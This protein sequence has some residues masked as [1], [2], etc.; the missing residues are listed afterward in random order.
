VSKPEFVDVDVA[1]SGQSWRTL[2]DA[3]TTL[4]L[5]ALDYLAD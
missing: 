5:A 2:S 4:D 3:L 1:I